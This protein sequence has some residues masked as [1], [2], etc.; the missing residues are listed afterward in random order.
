MSAATASAAVGGGVAICS[1]GRWRWRPRLQLG[2]GCG[3]HG[4]G[5]HGGG[6]F[7]GGSSG[8]GGC[9][10]GGGGGCSGGGISAKS[11][12]HAAIF[13]NQCRVCDASARDHLG[14][15]GRGA[16]VGCSGRSPRGVAA[17]AL[18]AQSQCA[19][20]HNHGVCVHESCASVIIGRH[21]SCIGILGNRGTLRP[22]NTKGNAIRRRGCRGT[23]TLHSFEIL[24]GSENH[25]IP[26]GSLKCASPSEVGCAGIARARRR[27]LLG[28]FGGRGGVR[29]RAAACGNA[30]SL[31]AWGGRRGRTHLPPLATG[32]RKKE[33][34]PS[35]CCFLSH[36]S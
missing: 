32:P 19:M 35:A 3:G 6:G 36:S 4:S 26:R 34:Q 12:S 7:R 14:I 9:H 21:Q 11:S 1:C 16:G 24:G 20:Q 5:G 28:K 23:H 18:A 10:G 8:G 22:Q 13:A 27:S 31:R 15:N 33:F 17:A 2:G 29:R 30:I 25:S